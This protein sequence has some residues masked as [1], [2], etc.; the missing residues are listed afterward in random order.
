VVNAV[1]RGK[2]VPIHVVMLVIPY[3]LLERVRTL[4]GR[5]RGEIVG[6][7]YAADITIAFHLPVETFD[8]FQNELREL[9]AG[10]AQAEIIETTEKV[11]AL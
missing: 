10:K 5:Q 1:G 3:H 11:V 2:R 9:S 8:R 4:I 6:E 7:D